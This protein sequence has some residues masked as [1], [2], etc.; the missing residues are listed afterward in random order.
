MSGK[1]VLVTGCTEGGIGHE[2]C[3]EYARR[4]AKVGGRCYSLQCVGMIT[5]GRRNA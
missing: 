5:E 1:V 3:K 2:L 4:G